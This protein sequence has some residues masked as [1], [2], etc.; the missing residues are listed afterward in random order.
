MYLH[1][2]LRQFL[3]VNIHLTEQIRSLVYAFSLRDIANVQQIN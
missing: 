1:E 2:E 3:E